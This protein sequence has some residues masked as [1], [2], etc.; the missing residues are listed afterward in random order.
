MKAL[1]DLLYLKPLPDSLSGKQQVLEDLR[2]R[3]DAITPADIKEFNS[4]VYL[5]HSPKM[6]QVST[7]IAKLSL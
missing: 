1:F 2:I 4:Y 7:I 6:R 3:F 5:T